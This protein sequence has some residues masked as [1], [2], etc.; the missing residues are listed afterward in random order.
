MGNAD[1]TLST[2]LGN[3]SQAY[4]NSPE[5]KAQQL[6][7]SNNDKGMSTIQTNTLQQTLLNRLAKIK[8]YGDTHPEP[9]LMGNLASATATGPFTGRL[10][11]IANGI[12]TNGKAADHDDLINLYKTVNYSEPQKAQVK[13]MSSILGEL[14]ATTLKEGNTARPLSVTLKSAGIPTF[15]DSDGYDPSDPKKVRNE[16]SAFWTAHEMAGSKAYSDN[17]VIGNFL[18]QHGFPQKQVEDAANNF[19]RKED[20]DPID[21]I[22]NKMDK[23][24]RVRTGLTPL[25]PDQDKPQEGPPVQ[26]QQQEPASALPPILQKFLDKS[27]G[28]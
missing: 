3:Q 2:N 17:Q 16:N 23:E 19:I 20:D 9:D 12:D 21:P 6:N 14:E 24:Y 26:A 27:G 11:D 28:P 18:V 22:L 1:Q 4:S 25:V 13:L 5:V 15:Y 8:Q 10:L 7:S